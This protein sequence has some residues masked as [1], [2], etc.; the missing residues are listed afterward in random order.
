MKEFFNII[1]SFNMK[2]I[3]AEPT[4]NSFLQFFRYGFVGG[5]AT[6]ADWGVLYLLTEWAKVH[7]LVSGVIA[8]VVGLLVNFLLSKKFVFSGEKNTH[9]SSTEFVVYAIIGVIGLI[10]TEI[11]MY[12]L[13]D[14]LNWYFMIPKIIATGVV[15]VW[16][17]MARKI[18][19]YR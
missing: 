12:V 16:N 5:W 7:Y 11:I 17:F 6:V 2:R 10:M 3:F 19:L 14:I 8:F 4:Q 1:F 18:V 9:S 15:F 13:T